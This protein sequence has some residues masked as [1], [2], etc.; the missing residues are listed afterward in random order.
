MASSLWL[1]DDE[2][3]YRFWREDLERH[4]DEAASHVNVRQGISNPDEA[5]R[6]TLGKAMQEG[7]ETFRPFLR[8]ERLARP[9]EP[10]VYCD[11]LD[12]TLSEVRSSEIAEAFLEKLEPKNEPDPEGILPGENEDEASE[13]PETEKAWGPERATLRA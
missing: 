2:D 10:D 11:I 9:S 12:A 1:S 4:R 8:G 13:T 6:Y 3:S 7:F 5:A